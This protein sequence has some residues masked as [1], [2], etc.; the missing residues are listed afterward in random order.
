MDDAYKKDVFNVTLAKSK[1]MKG[2]TTKNTLLDCVTIFHKKR[3]RK[4]SLSL[5]VWLIFKKT[6][7][8]TK[9]T[10]LITCVH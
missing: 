6:A 3:F 1:R 8:T 9:Q 7:T 5:L 10:G 2:S 4:S